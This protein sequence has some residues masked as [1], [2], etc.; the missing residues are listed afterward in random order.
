MPMIRFRL[1]GSRADADTLIIGL[2]GIDGIEYIEE[3]DD[4]TLSFRDL[5]SANDSDAHTYVIE[6]GTASDSLAGDVRVGA[7]ALAHE[8]NAGIEF[9]DAF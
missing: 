1:V 6:V 7:A 3:I 9:V 4:P 8:R 2:H 5:D